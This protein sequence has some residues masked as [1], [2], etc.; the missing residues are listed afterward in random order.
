[1]F[2]TAELQSIIGSSPVRY[3]L[4]LIRTFPVFSGL[5]RCGGEAKVKENKLLFEQ[6]TIFEQKTIFK[7]KT[8]FEQKPIFEKNN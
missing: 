7:Q 4:D 2:D 1:M 3:N 5:H 8:I 6:E